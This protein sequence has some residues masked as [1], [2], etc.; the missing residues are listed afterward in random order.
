[1]ATRRYRFESLD[2]ISAGAVGA[3]GK[4]TF[5]LLVRDGGRQLRIW[6]EKQLFQS[7][8]LGIQRVL[9]EL[10][11]VQS[12]EETIARTPPQVNPEYG[13]GRE[14][15]FQARELAVGYDQN[16]H[17]VGIFLYDREETS[18]SPTFAGWGTKAQMEALSKEIDEVCAAGRPLC[19][20][21]MQ[22]IDREGHVCPRSNG[23]GKIA[24]A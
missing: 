9:L 21:C 4:R 18:R 23:H 24:Q 13:S 12:Q 5:Y 16:R 6:L 17:R 14:Q 3:P 2:S 20:L 22:P 8:S 10:A 1:M 19:F 7:L 11:Q 15:E